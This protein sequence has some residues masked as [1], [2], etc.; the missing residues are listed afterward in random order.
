MP[1]A[2]GQA[3]RA[4]I[5]GLYEQGREAEEVRQLLLLIDWLLT[6]PPEVEALVRRQLQADEEEFKMAHI[7]SWEQMALERGLAEGEAR[8]KA[9]GQRAAL[10]VLAE[11]RFGPAPEGFAA[12]LDRADEEALSK[13]T[14]RLAT[15]TTIEQAL[16]GWSA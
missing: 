12:M 13:L 15:A 5:R 16:E 11:A 1:A 9:E 6:L 4:I 2:R 14:V 3:K 7:T 8:G 10:Y